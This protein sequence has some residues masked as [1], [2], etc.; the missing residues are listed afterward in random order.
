MRHKGNYEKH[1]AQRR[2]HYEREDTNGRLV[3]NLRDISHTMRL[4]LIH[5]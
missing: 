5:F 1:V 4:S 2:A 3:I